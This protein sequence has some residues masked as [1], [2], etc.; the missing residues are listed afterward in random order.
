MVMAQDFYKGT[1][2]SALTANRGG[3]GGGGGVFAQSI[4]NEGIGY[5]LQR[6]LKCHTVSLDC[7]FAL[8]CCY[9]FS[10]AFTKCEKR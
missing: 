8:P 3:G 7:V 5:L 1:I 4:S 6:T 2:F 10:T 9:L